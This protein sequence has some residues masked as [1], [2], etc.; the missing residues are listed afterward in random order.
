MCD[1]QSWGS[2]AGP[3]SISSLPNGS[4]LSLLST[5]LCL[6]AYG[7]PVAPEVPP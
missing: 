1:A 2:L 4:L 3:V 6:L 7:K 5:W